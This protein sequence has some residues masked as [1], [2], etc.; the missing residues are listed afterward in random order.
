MIDLTC[1]HTRTDHITI[2]LLTG[3]NEGDK[4]DDR[5]D[6]DVLERNDKGEER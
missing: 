5:W 1:T 3:G 6:R 4:R 2:R